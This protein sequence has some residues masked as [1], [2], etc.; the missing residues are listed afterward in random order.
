MTVYSALELHSFTVLM[1]EWCRCY[2]IQY[3]INV[4]ASDSTRSVSS[5][6]PALSI[7]VCCNS[8]KYKFW[9]DVCC[10]RRRYEILLVVM[11]PSHIRPHYALNSV[12]LAYSR[13]ASYEMKIEETVGLS[14]STISSWRS[15]GSKGH[16]YM[17]I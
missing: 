17:A 7:V 11:R 10:V 16:G 2:T 13:T 3:V 12:R 6:L 5:D 15:I 1:L 9:L 8:A 4:N 14:R